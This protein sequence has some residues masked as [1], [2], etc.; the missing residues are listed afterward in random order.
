MLSR[1]GGAGKSREE[2]DKHKRKRDDA[3]RAL[4]RLT[5]D[6][7]KAQGKK[8]KNRLEKQKQNLE[9]QLQGHEKEIR[10]KWPSGRPTA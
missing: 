2:Y 6:L 9:R 8:V 10:Q 3:R 5:R 7:A 4:R 1:G